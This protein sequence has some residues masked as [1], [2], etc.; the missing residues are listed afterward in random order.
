MGK[1]KLFQEKLI[2]LPILLFTIITPLLFIFSLGIVF[3]SPPI[4]NDDTYSTNEDETLIITAPLGVLSNDNEVGSGVAVLETAP[5]T[6]TVELISTGAFTYTPLLDFNGIITFSYYVSKTDEITDVANVEITVTAVNDAPTAGNDNATTP[7]DTA[8]SIPILANDGDIDGS[9]DPSSVAIVT[10]PTNGTTGVNLTTG[11]VTYTP[12]LNFNGND[13]FVYQVYDDGIPTP[14]LSVT[15][16]VYLTVTAVN[17]APTAEDDS[18]T[19]TEDSIRNIASPGVLENDSDVDN[20][21]TRLV[22]DFDAFSSSGAVVSVNVDG[23]YTYNPTNSSVLNAL[24]ITETTIDTFTYTISDSGGLTDT[25]TVSIT[26]TGVNDS[27]T[28]VDDSASINEDNILTPPIPGVLAGDTDPDTSD[29]LTAVSGNTTS[30][31]GAAVTINSNGTYTYNPQN[32]AILQALNTGDSLQDTFS[33]TVTDGHGGN[34]NGTVTVTVGGSNDAPVI[35]NTGNMVLANINEDQSNSSGTLVSAIISSVS[36]DRI[37]DA[38]SGAVE[39]IAVVGVTNI[40]GNWQYSLNG[41]DW[42]PFNTVSDY[43][44]VLLDTTEYIR[45]VPNANYNGSAGTISFRAW[46]QTVGSSGAI[47]INVST[48]GLTT[49]YS[50]DSETATL[51]V[52]SVN[53]APVLDNSGNMYLT[54]IGEDNTTNPGDSVAAIIASP[55]G[56]R[57]T[58]VDFGDEEGIAVTGVDN[59]HGTWQYSING[60]LNWS[61]LN[62]SPTSARLLDSQSRI[63]FVPQSNY[64]GT[65]G[66]ITFQAWDLSSGTL[67][68]TENASQNG[69]TTAFSTATETANLNVYSINDA[70]FLDLDGGGIG[71]TNFGATFTEDGGP[72]LIVDTDLSVSDV[73]DSNLTSAQAVL[74]NPFDGTAE[75]LTVNTGTTGIT[76]VYSPTTGILSLTGSVSL[77]NYQTV[78]RT[79]SYNNSSQDPNTDG[80]VVQVRVNDG[81]DNSNL[82]TSFV[83]INAVNDNPILVN[84]TTL[85]VNEGGTATISVARLQVADV[86]NTTSERTFTVISPPSH[87]DLLLSGSPLTANDTF[88]QADIDSSFVDYSNDGSEFSS[89]SFTFTVADGSGGSIGVTPFNIEVNP[90]ND[91]PVLV[92]NAALVLDEQATQT[93]TV[94]HLQVTDADNTAVDLTYRLEAAPVNGD[95]LLNSLPLLTNATFTQ[96]DINNSKL[97]YAHDGS[98]TTSDTFTFSVEDGSGGTIDSTL[99]AITINP[100][101]DAPS[102]DLNGPAAGVNFAADFTEDGGPVTIADSTSIVFDADNSSLLSATAALAN[103][104][105]GT[106]ESLSANTGGTNISASYNP[107]TGVLTLSGIDSISNYQTVLRSLQYNNATQDPTVTNRIVNVTV[108]DGLAS[109]N[110]ASST[111]TIYAVNDLPVL[112]VN[113]GLT[114]DYGQTGI[115][116]N[117][118]LRITDLDNSVSELVYTVK[119]LPV[120]GQLKRN[121][122]PLALNGTFTQADINGGLL[123]YTHNKT[124]TESDSFQFTAVDSSGGSISQKTFAIVIHPQPIVY[125]PV[126]LNN[127]IYSEPNDSACAAF[128]V[129]FNNSYQFLPDDTEDWYKFT[130]NTTSNIGIQISNYASVDGQMIVYAGSNCTS[131]VQIR[132]LPDISPDGSITLPG[133]TAGTY[134]VRVYTAVIPTNPPPYTL[135][136]TKP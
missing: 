120:N 49:P 105:D 75:S 99:F 73:D 2:R 123:A 13:S 39:G 126:I 67:G 72:I 104:P 4:A 96:A 88:T 127:Y 97:S 48:N 12:T 103:R 10:A 90:D 107:A 136:I 101:N 80:R 102:V 37:T 118:L 7:E 81:T 41:S 133:L 51:T 57:I 130:L 5:L 92:V 11:A 113:A 100:V 21:D 56:D 50:V 84:N 55:G 18:E 62:G 85:P 83:S 53:D 36:G 95:L 59:S 45:F 111:V 60:G 47:N 8:V 46:D 74:I 108:H 31:L 28:A 93:I 54:S 76:A 29:T 69:G 20:G 109:S 122:T 16:T 52:L 58:D 71:S 132:H 17:D 35:D 124:N 65:S 66:N 23:G 26:V 79:L 19:T 134:Y 15:A 27:P 82:T 78:L 1:T 3:A 116:N 9:L 98:E 61:S 117:S 110:V 106:A 112:S 33:Y 63:R 91:S 119:S 94:S 125:L 121:G 70:P 14:A 30:T 114:V 87:G 32:V 42:S 135:R 22:T 64:F 131:I 44:A 89:D 128:G 34:D 129:T 38:D 6:G 115:I 40:N 25:A 43:N 77:I 68:A 24:A 86:D